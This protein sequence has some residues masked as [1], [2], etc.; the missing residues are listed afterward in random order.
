MAVWSFGFQLS[1]AG[2][3]W[4]RGGVGNRLD[5]DAPRRLYCVAT[6]PAEG[7]LMARMRLPG[8]HRF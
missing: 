8:R 1:G 2:G 3:G 5:A 7:R 6:D 4:N